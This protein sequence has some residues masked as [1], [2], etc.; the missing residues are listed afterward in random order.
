MDGVKY[1]A[2]ALMAI[3]IMMGFAVMGYAQIDEPE[4]PQ[5]MGSI[6]QVEIK[7]MTITFERPRDIIWV[8]SDGD[9]HCPNT[10]STVSI[11]IKS[12]GHLSLGHNDVNLFGVSDTGYMSGEIA[13]LNSPHRF[14][15]FEPQMLNDTHF[16][17]NGII[18]DDPRYSHVNICA[19]KH[20]ADRYA[21]DFFEFDYLGDCSGDLMVWTAQEDFGYNVTYTEHYHA[22]CSDL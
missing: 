1:V 19:E 8:V 18:F 6:S 20:V 2:C 7:N 15:I 3:G 22:Y 9:M 14:L 21:D 10:N 4:L 16:V 13:T 11:G 5:D 17:G 12:D